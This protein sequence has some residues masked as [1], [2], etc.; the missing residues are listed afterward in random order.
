MAA[1]VRFDKR[2]LIIISSILV[3]LL[4]VL[5]IFYITVYQW[6]ESYICP[7]LIA[8]RVGIEP[9]YLSIR[10]YIQNTLTPGIDRSEVKARLEKIGRVKIWQDNLVLFGTMTDEIHVIL[11]YDP[12]DNIIIFA[13]YSPDEK[14]IRIEFEGE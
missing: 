14:L 11:C 5:P 6:A 12:M 13:H 4:C 7:R 1:K 10:E 8:H 3:V 2:K 9:S